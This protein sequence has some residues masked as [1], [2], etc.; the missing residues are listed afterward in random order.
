[1][2]FKARHLIFPTHKRCELVIEPI[3]P[4]CVDPSKE[5]TVV[6]RP[7]SGLRKYRLRDSSHPISCEDEA[8]FAAE[9]KL[10]KQNNALCIDACFP[11]EDAY[12]CKVYLEGEPV[13]KFEVYALEEDLFGKTPYLGDN[14][15]HTAFSDGRESPA[16]MAAA[17]CRKGYDYC[18]ITDHRLYEPSIEARDFF[19][20][21]NTDFL[22]IPGEEVHSPDNPVHIISLGGEQSVN[23]WWREKEAEYRA[24]VE[25]ELQ[26]TPTEMT[27]SDR[28]AAAASQV[29]FEKIREANG[30]SVLCHPHWICGDILHQHEDIT[31][32]LTEHKKFDILELLAGGAHEEGVQ[33]QLSYFKDYPSMPMVGSSDA[34]AAFEGGLKLCNYTVVFADALSTEAIKEALRAGCA[35][36]ANEADHFFGC[37]RLVRYAYFLQRNYFPRHKENREQLGQ[38]MLRLATRGGAFPYN[39][40]DEKRKNLR[41]SEAFAA[42][43]YRE[44]V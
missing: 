37:Y 13:G 42:L 6:I 29:M 34:H 12:L 7:F 19:A 8:F 5:Y 4:V 39:G 22:V 41:P 21:F 28:Y 31:E 24:A 14:H 10:N 26:N 1:M 18:V 9:H 2:Y 3:F 32:Y 33:M 43:C 20:P 35:V 17:A 16:Y 36:A 44:E 23:D 30:L 25:K 40:K 38:W 27:Q 15:M 11:Q